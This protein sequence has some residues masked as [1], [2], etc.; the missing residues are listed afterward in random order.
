MQSKDETPLS[1]TNS[2]MKTNETGQ[3]NE[4]M[5]IG[6]E[7]YTFSALSVSPIKSNREQMKYS[8]KIIDKS[9][10]NSKNYAIAKKFK[11]RAI[12]QMLDKESKGKQELETGALLPNGMPRKWKMCGFEGCDYRAQYKSNLNRHQNR[13]GHKDIIGFTNKEIAKSE[14]ADHSEANLSHVAQKLSALQNS[15][16][17]NS[18]EHKTSEEERR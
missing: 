14:K 3:I 6:D 12:K 4:K 11:Q 7:S 10:G 1:T 5:D 9:S 16:K 15:T 2:I 17:K 18:K 13:Y 8:R